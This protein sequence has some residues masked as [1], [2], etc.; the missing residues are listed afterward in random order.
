MVAHEG[1]PIADPG[2]ARPGFGAAWAASMRSQASHH[3]DLG[4]GSRY[5]GYTTG[6]SEPG[7]PTTEGGRW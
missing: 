7:T 3:C 2:R 6:M 1:R 4:H 5:S